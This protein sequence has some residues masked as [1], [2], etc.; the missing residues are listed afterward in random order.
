MF[1]DNDRVVVVIGVIV[2]LECIVMDIVRFVFVG[3]FCLFLC[4][5][6]V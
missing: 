1:V 2:R 3:N 4:V 6:V 5:F